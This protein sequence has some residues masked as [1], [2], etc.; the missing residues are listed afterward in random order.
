MNAIHPLALLSAFVLEEGRTWG[1]VA[2]D[3]QRKD[4]AAII[5]RD[6]PRRH[7]LLRGRGM[8]KTTDIAGVALALLLTQAPARSRSYI[9]AADAD[10]AALFMDALAGMVGRTPGLPGAVEVGAR[11]VTVRRGGASLS[12][13]TSDGASAFGL[14]P[15]LIIVDELG[16]WP[17][18]ANMRRLWSAIVSALPKVPGSRLIVIG[19][20]GSP[21]GLGAKVWHEAETS[22]EWRASRNPGPSPWWTPGE[23][24]A[25]LR[26]LTAAEYRRLILCEWAEGDDALTSPEDVAA[27]IRSK[28]LVLPPYPG[29]AYFAALDLG[30]R[31]D[32]SA[33]VIG[34][35]E[36]RQGGRVTV[37]DRLTYWRPGAGKAGRVD[38][39]EVEETV[40][41]LAREYRVGAVLYDRHQAEGLT[42]GLDRAGVTV[43]E[44]V[45]SAASVNTLARSLFIA[46]RD[47]ALEMPEDSELVEQFVATHIVETNTGVKLSNPVG[48]H[49]DIPTVIGM[50]HLKLVERG[51]TGRAALTVPRSGTPIKRTTQG[52]DRRE[53]SRSAAL[54]G[55]ARDAASLPIGALGR[56]MGR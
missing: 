2:E 33:F 43:E 29:T 6:G 25:T 39:S 18:T 54:R 50:L 7:N 44:F 16:I 42:Q 47:R 28:P 5:D 10:Q 49:D 40:K 46:L 34:H 53:V 30:T 41:R 38:L 17:S 8:S 12:V 11:T 3:F 22:E 52:P 48:A 56:R 27:A 13:E 4:A 1:E 24:A 23:I 37:V 36:Q 15:W 26:S 35:S 51:D 14:R 55:L 19:T 20:A 32:L 31:R 45:F 9:Y 21:N